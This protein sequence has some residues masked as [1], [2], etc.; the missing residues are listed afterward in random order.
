MMRTPGKR[1]GVVWALMDVLLG[2]VMS[3]VGFLLNYFKISLQRNEILS[4]FS[5]ISSHVFG[6]FNALNPIC[7]VGVQW[8]SP[9]GL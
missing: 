3:T 7:G 4:L 5:L 1:G 9:V 2:W 6:S 8:C